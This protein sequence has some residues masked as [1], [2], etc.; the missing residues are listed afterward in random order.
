ML[1]VSSFTYVYYNKY[2]CH[3]LFEWFLYEMDTVL[4]FVMSKKYSCP[5]NKYLYYFSNKAFIY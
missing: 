4:E 5:Q 1:P 2:V 3:T